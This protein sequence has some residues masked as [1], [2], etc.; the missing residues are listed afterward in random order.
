MSDQGTIWAVSVFVL[1]SIAAWC[2]ATL[3]REYLERRK[4]ELQYEAYAMQLSLRTDHREDKRVITLHEDPDSD[5]CISLRISDYNRIIHDTFYFLNIT[6]E[7][8]KTYETSP[9][10]TSPRRAF[11]AFERELGPNAEIVKTKLKALGYW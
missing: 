9:P 10:S 3:F 2:V 1:V 7:T 11:A 6:H 8:T 4:L 5:L